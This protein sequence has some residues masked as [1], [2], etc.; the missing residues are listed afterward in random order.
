MICNT[1]TVLM[2]L[3]V[4][5]CRLLST[6]RQASGDILKTSYTNFASLVQNLLNV[7]FEKE[8]FFQVSESV[9]NTCLLK[10]KGRLLLL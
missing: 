5:T 9:R 6:S 8:L 10:I 7:P 3:F 1:I 2:Y 4:N